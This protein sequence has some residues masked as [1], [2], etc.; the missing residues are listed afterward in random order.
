LISPFVLG[1]LPTLWNEPGRFDPTRFRPTL[2]SHDKYA[3]IPFGSGPRVCVARQLALLQLRAIVGEVTAG[4][5]LGPLAGAAPDA[6]SATRRP[7]CRVRAV[8]A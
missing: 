2:V 1:R 7:P 3:H 5:D 8:A 6:G 4:L